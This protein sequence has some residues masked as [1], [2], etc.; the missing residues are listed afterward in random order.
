MSL[1]KSTSEKVH[2][3]YDP[4]DGRIIHVHMTTTVEGATEPPSD[5]IEAAASRAA[6]RNGVNLN[7]LA[8]LNVS[9]EQWDSRRANR[10]D[11]NTKALSSK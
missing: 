3:I 5:H 8:R 2:V 11:L 10:V 7:G 4:K 9:R 1:M 6:E